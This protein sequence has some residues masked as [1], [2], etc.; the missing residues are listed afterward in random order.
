MGGSDG[1]ESGRKFVN[2][3]KY[4]QISKRCR[5][6]VDV[7]AAAVAATATVDVDCWSS[8]RKPTIG[9]DHFA[10]IVFVTSALSSRF[11]WFFSGRCLSFVFA[12]AAVRVA[13]LT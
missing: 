3:G 5:T 12:L 2:M 1:G 9:H 13:D 10:F 6:S 8:D 11:Y 4:L 7:A